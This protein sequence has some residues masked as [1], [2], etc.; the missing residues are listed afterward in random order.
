MRTHDG[1]RRGPVH[2]AEVNPIAARLGEQS[3]NQSADLAGAQDQYTVHRTLTPKKGR[4]LPANA[5][6]RQPPW[7]S[8]TSPSRGARQRREIV[9]G[10]MRSRRQKPPP[11]TA[12]DGSA[13]QP[14]S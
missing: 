13:A 4:I 11:C 6:A 14:P 1:L 10:S 12:R 8:P 9:A 3:R 7:G 2:I 5:A